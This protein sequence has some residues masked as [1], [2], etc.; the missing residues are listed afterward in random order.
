MAQ[1][2]R[3]DMG[4]LFSGNESPEDSEPDV[5]RVPT[6]FNYSMESWSEE[7]GRRVYYKGR[8]YFF[9]GK[10]KDTEL[11]GIWDILEKIPAALLAAEKAEAEAAQA[12]HIA[13]KG[14]ECWDNAQH[15]NEPGGALGGDYYYCTL[16]NECLQVG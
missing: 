5:I 3:V 14:H 13:E 12:K 9:K 7:K 11:T 10:E 8:W 2:Y 4:N 15:G 6:Q 16:C 1:F